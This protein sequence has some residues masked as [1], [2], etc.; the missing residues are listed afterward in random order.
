MSWTDKHHPPPTIKKKPLS[1]VAL[2]LQGGGALGA[3]QGGA[4]AAMEETGIQPD[5]VSGISIGAINAAIIAGN[6]PEQRAEKLKAFWD[7][8]ATGHSGPSTIVRNGVPGFFTPAEHAAGNVFLN[9]SGLKDLL[10]SHVKE[11]ISLY[12][13]SP[14]YETL[15]QFVDFD[16]LNS[17]HNKTR[18]SVGA[19]DVETR[20]L[21]YFDNKVDLPERNARKMKT[22]GIMRNQQAIVKTVIDP[23]HIMASGALIPNFPAVKIDHRHY[24][25]GGLV[26]NTPVRFAHE[27]GQLSKDMLVVRPDLW[28]PTGSIPKTHDKALERQLEIQFA[29]PPINLDGI[30][31][32]H[33]HTL[34]ARR[35]D[36]SHNKFY[37][38]SSDAVHK[39]WAAGHH[40]MK[41]A[42][43]DY[44]KQAAS[45]KAGTIMAGNG[46]DVSLHRSN[47]GAHR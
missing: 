11:H 38:F 21:V 4:Y 46:D 34:C 17:P 44:K 35:T 40:D 39:N 5:W 25:D 47:T 19:A 13:P 29:S 30:V 8:I 42:L 10:G 43:L 26:S 33:I 45:K 23:A 9:I 7:R 36:Q 18:L 37:D 22:Y 16:Y 27:T 2:F 20:K 41:T 31:A 24:C 28:N 15:T 14:M 1:S 32:G 6:P 3:Y 12:D